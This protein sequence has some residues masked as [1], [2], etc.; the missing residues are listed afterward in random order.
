MKKIY[1]YLAYAGVL[2]FVMC[3]ALLLLGSTNIPVLGQTQ[4]VLS[5]YALVITSF[6]A[7]SHWGQ[8][9][10]LEAR[11]AKNIYLPVFSNIVAL[12]LWASFLMLPFGPLMGI[13]SAAFIFLLLIDRVLLRQGLITRHYFQ[14]RCLVTSLV[15]ATL[16]ISGLLT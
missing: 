16:L 4:T 9:L 8:H 11:D 15:V 6:M 14:T 3:T 13:C 10:Y 5:V 7:G 2:P 12:V 1:P